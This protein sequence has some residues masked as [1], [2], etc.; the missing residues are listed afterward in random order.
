MHEYRFALRTQATRPLPRWSHQRSSLL[1][2]DDAVR[3]TEK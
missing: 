1:K 2:R 3:Q